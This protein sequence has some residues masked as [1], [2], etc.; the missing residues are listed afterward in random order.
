MPLPLLAL[1]PLV[2]KFLPTILNMVSPKGGGV[3]GGILKDL[4]SGKVSEE[5]ANAKMIEA[6]SSAQA[7]ISQNQASVIKAEVNSDSWLARNWRPIMALTYGLSY[8]YVIMVIPH[9]VS[10]GMMNAPKFGEIGLENMFYLT[11][12]A[13]GGYVG[14]RSL[15]KIAKTISR[16]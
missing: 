13:I 4:E 9:L 3:V 15:E 16:R 12:V 1:A 5:E 11:M 6:L 8:W 7:E 10:W 2:L 14:G